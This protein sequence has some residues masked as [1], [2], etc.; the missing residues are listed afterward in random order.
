MLCLDQGRGLYEAVRSLEEVSAQDR[1]ELAEH[2]SQ[3]T[4]P[5]VTSPGFQELYVQT[6]LSSLASQVL[7]ASRHHRSILS[8]SRMRYRFSS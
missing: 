2:I 5:S 8:T 3:G 1:R 4:A 6:P 7:G